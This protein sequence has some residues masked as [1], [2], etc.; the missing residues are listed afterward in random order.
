MPSE[1]NRDLGIFLVFTGLVG[2]LPLYYLYRTLVLQSPEWDW[3]Q[4]AVLGFVLVCLGYGL[5]A[6]TRR[7]FRVRDGAVEVRDGLLRRPI[8]YVFRESPLVR[9]QVLEIEGRG[10]PRDFWQVMLV[11]GKYEYLL[12]SRP[13]QMQESRCLA[14]FVAK[15]IGCPLKVRLEAGQIFQI[16]AEDLDLPFG[17]LVQRY[18]DLLGSRVPRPDC[19]P[20]REEGQGMSRRFR[21]GMRTSS[22]L[23]ETVGLF[24]VALAVGFV[25]MSGGGE[26]RPSLFDL[27][28]SS[29][30]YT[31]FM[32]VCG[33]FLAALF[34]QFGYQVQVNLSPERV[35]ART[36]LWGLPIWSASIATSV[37]EGI[38]VR[39]RSQGAFLQFVSDERIVSLRVLR[40]ELAE[41][42][43]SE[44]RYAL[45]GR[46]E[47]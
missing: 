7:T 14:E 3:R 45:A 42:L 44:L 33:L 20:I 27:A 10:R 47:Q 9:L 18:P 26:A 23:N 22:L 31:Y 41:Y 38:S 24:A 1:A 6:F 46:P 39:T 30:D 43:G 25:P 40:R 37:L 13:E 11:D 21:W 12:D 19:C 35:G 29:Q 8:R 2:S 15:Q 17:A 32:A 36:T 4:G 16:E 28:R 34:L 5:V